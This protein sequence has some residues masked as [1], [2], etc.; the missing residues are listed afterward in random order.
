M[1][2]RALCAEFKTSKDGV[3][4]KGE[5]RGHFSRHAEA[6]L[7]A[8]VGAM[9]YAETATAIGVDEVGH[10]ASLGEL[11]SFHQLQT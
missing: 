1:F 3:G 5:Y 4:L 8:L 9:T 11:A 6:T 10:P 7:I 2:A